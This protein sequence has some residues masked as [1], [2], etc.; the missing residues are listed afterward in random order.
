MTSILCYSN[1]DN[2]AALYKE[3]FCFFSRVTRCK[4]RALICIAYNGCS[5]LFS[6]DELKLVI[7]QLNHHFKKLL[8]LRMGTIVIHHLE[9]TLFEPAF[10]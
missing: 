8:D 10:R 3:N 9:V 7:R 2:A 5:Y 1:V 6:R 4:K